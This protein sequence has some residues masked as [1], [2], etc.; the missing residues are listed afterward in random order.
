MKT[1]SFE[2]LVLEYN[3]KLSD[4]DA[5]ILH[6]ATMTLRPFGTLDECI[7][8]DG[9]IRVYTP[10]YGCR[11]ICAVFN[12]SCS[13]C[14]RCKGFTK[15]PQ[16]NELKL[17]CTTHDFNKEIRVIRTYE[18][19]TSYNHSSKL[20][21]ATPHEVC[22]HWIAT[23]GESTVIAKP[24]VLGKIIHWWPMSIRR[25]N[26]VLYDYYADI[27]IRYP[28]SSM[29]QKMYH[30]ILETEVELP[31]TS[32]YTLLMEAVEIQHSI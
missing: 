8:A 6:W 1:S 26:R 15:A 20:H 25:K 18:L 19:V 17:F 10:E 9:A 5:R 3:A 4:L 29:P 23:T 32:T 21:T 14:H 30:P 28:Y 31:D 27:A 7:K 22:R 13:S 16:K 24:I 12:P 11:T 2:N